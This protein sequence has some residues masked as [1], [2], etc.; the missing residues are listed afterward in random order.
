MSLRNA[1]GAIAL[2]ASVQAVNA[3]LPALASGRV[4]VDGSG[5]TQPV[6]IAGSVAVTGA[7]TDTQLRASAVSVTFPSAQAVTGPLTDSQLRASAVPV[8]A[9]SLPLPTGAASETTLA[10]VNAKLPALTNGT[11]PVTIGASQQTPSGAVRVGNSN[12]K[13]RDEFV[14]GGLRADTWDLISTGAGMSVSTGNGTTGSYLRITTGTTANSETIIRSKEIVG[15]PLRFAAFVTASQ[16]IANQE[17]FLELIEVDASGAPIA[18]TSQ[19]NA[20]TSPNHAS[21]KFDGTTATTALVTARSGDAPEFVSAASTITTT[22]ATGTGPNFFPAGY[23]ELMVSGEAVQLLQAP[24]DATAAVTV[25]RRVTQAAPD[26][27]K[28]YKLQI[29]ARNLG[30]APASTTDWR[31]HAIRV[32]DFTR[33]DVQIVG[34][35]GHNAPGASVPVTV[36]SGSVTVSGTVTTAGA[37][38]HDAVISGNPTRIAGRALTANYTA[39][40]TGDTA[41]LVTTLV[42]AL[43]QKPYSIPELDWQFAGALTTT[44]AVPARAAQAAGIRNYVTG[45]QFSNSGASAVDVIVLDGTTVI[46]QATVAAGAFIRACFQTPLRGTAAT[47]LNVNLSAAGTV[48]A[49]VQGYSAP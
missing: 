42:G 12:V 5:V 17:L 18:G 21:V 2:D 20:G 10:A 32:F 22:V 6:S 19:T 39:V 25:A 37:A 36:G 40:A 30:T 8:S 27:N 47:A 48:R 14:T 4:P 33:M 35:V 16:R 9:A 43:V 45:V 26:P 23:V 34:G 15:L 24:I 7:L 41:D 49:N 44:T 3:K 29:R 1:F 46:F 38:A 11:V 13:L 28:L 31:V